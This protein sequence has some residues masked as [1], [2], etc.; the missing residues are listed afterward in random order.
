MKQGTKIEDTKK[1]LNTMTKKVNY[2]TPLA[3]IKVTIVC[4]FSS[5]GQGVWAVEVLTLKDIYAASLSYHPSQQNNLIDLDIANNDVAVERAASLPTI[6]LSSNVV[7]SNRSGTD[8]E[9]IKL[10]IKQPIY[11]RPNADKL[12]IALI[13]TE[14][15]KQK[16]QEAKQ[17]L[18]LEIAD[19]YTQVLIQTDKEKLIKQALKEAQILH[20]IVARA[21]ELEQKAPLELYR[22][23]ADV[24]DKQ[25]SLITS[26]SHKKRL[27]HEL[28]NYI[29]TPVNDVQVVVFSSDEFAVVMDN[30]LRIHPALTRA[31][32]EQRRAKLA[33]AMAQSANHPTVDLTVDFSHRNTSSVLQTQASGENRAT[34]S[35]NWNL[36][37]GHANRYTNDNAYKRLL[38]KEHEYD[39]IAADINQKIMATEALIVA[40]KSK[41]EALNKAIAAQQHAVQTVEKSWQLGLVN[42]GEIQT[43]YSTLYETQMQVFTEQRTIDLEQLRLLF[44]TGA[45]DS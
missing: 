15:A 7:A 23:V 41:L 31:L 22:A 9:E 43:Q 29:E 33:M 3:W 20:K 11:N 44:L 28:M 42:I 12:K 37:N 34:L 19:I 32:L 4:V 26:T 35:M 5:M 27:Q 16:H 13:D 10:S 30:K 24:A 39:R 40:S 1:L 6:D 18:L 14:I 17:A 36:F 21:V 38:Q 2:I 45:L 8:Y 25:A